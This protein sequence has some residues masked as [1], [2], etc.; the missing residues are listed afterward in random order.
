MILTAYVWTYMWFHCYAFQREFH[1]TPVNNKPTLAAHPTMVYILWGRRGI[2]TFFGLILSHRLITAQIDQYYMVSRGAFF[3]RVIFNCERHVTHSDMVIACAPFCYV[4]T[5]PRCYAFALGLGSCWVCG[6][7]IPT[8]GD[9]T[10]ATAFWVDSGKY[11][12]IVINFDV[13]NL[14][15]MQ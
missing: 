10:T 4:P 15:I 5:R 13:L 3:N 9:M 14:R 12:I 6:E 8:H 1:T 7:G 2:W 11:Q